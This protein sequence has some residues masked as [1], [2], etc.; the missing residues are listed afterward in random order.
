ML[1]RS[2]AL[3]ALLLGLPALAGD[4]PRPITHEDL[5][6]MPR[7]GQPEISPD[8]RQ[9]I[10]EVTQP[11]Y[12]SD[13]QASHL[14]LVTTDGSGPP[15]Q[16]TFARSRESGV[17]WS[18][19]SRRIAFTTRR[20]GDKASQV[21][22]LDLVAGGEAERV[23]SVST[24]ARAPR[25]S[26]DG[27]RIAFTSDVPPGAMDDE[28]SA[29]LLEEESARKHEVY[30]YTGFPIRNWDRW[31]PER[32][33]RLLVQ[34]LGED[35]AID[36]LAGSELVTLPGYGGRSTPGG[37]ELDAVWAPD[38][39]SLVFVATRNRDRA[40][41]DF[42]N[43]ELWQVPATGGEPQRLTGHDSA[44]GG[45][46]WGAPA[47]S[48]DGAS[49]YALRVPRTDRVYNAARLVRLDW[50]S[51]E[52]RVEIELPEARAV[53]EY[54]ISPDSREV[55]MLADD[56]AHVKLF[57]ADS[58]GRDIRLAFDMDSG[59]YTGLS[60]ARLGNRPLLLASFQ[61]AVSPP[62]VVRLDLRRGG[63]QALTRFT[64]E[65]VAE[66]DL[67]P[68]ENFWFENAAGAQVHS[69]LVRPANFDPER[70]YP[71]FVMMR[72]GPHLNSR[73]YFFLRWNYHLLAGTD[74]VVLMTNYTGSTG[75]G[76]AFAQAIQGDPLAGPAEDINQAAD[77]AIARFDFI[78]GERQCAGGASYGGHLANWM[79]SATDR[80]RCLV[81]HAGLVNLATQWAT[82]DVIYSREVNL[83][84]PP[85]LDEEFPVWLE[86]NPIRFAENWQTPVLV[87]IGKLD[88]RVP[89][90]NVLEYWSALQRQQI[91]S[92]LLV[93]PKEN[94]WI[95]NGH[96]SRHFYGEVTDWLARWLL[97]S[98]EE[99]METAEAEP[100]Q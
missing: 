38:G 18:P 72:G 46:S 44:E 43:T 59:I 62:E 2:L 91:E 3:L 64:A 55:F 32:Q 42:T 9:A 36:L 14:W 34:T 95:L 76:E 28:D 73:D 21:Y 12:D 94:H 8:G 58:R 16:L 71:L 74:V 78:D 45:D 50:P 49:L 29:R 79:Q 52:P 63:H 20:D 70:R 84:G 13:E 83:G 24:G 61:S 100:A 19:D 33:P 65:R 11:A 90:A 51:A 99:A 40:A 75:F 80:Y 86:Q 87:T 6:L 89:L 93:Y 25:F 85:W 27:N 35:A 26:P 66:L 22:V 5:W 88:Y 30:T 69:M 39:E 1:V 7:V 96:N 77:E 92:R 57:R 31:L 53:L 56:A 10:V 98:P 67:Q 97:E 81:S 82:S 47:F 54:S 23:T 37:S 15:R 41:F 48:P 68:V 17:T 4:G 60:G